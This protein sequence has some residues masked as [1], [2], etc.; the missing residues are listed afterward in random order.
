MQLY[1]ANSMEE[2]SN[3]GYMVRQYDS[4]DDYNYVCVCVYQIAY[5]QLALEKVKSIGK[6]PRGTPDVVKEAIK[7]LSEFLTLK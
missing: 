5:Q 2:Q 1:Q 4:N 3:Y 7:N 6:P